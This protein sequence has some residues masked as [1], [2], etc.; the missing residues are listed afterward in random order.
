VTEETY[1]NRMDKFLRKALEEYKLASLYKLIRKGDVKVNGKRVKDP[2]STLEIGDEV[3]VWLPSDQ[4]KKDRIKRNTEGKREL[5]PVYMD[6]DIIMEDEDIMAINKDAG[7]S[8]HPGTGEE[9]R[10]TLIEGLM[11]YGQQNGFDPYLIHRLDRDTSGVLLVSKKRSLARRLSKLIADKN[12]Y[13]EYT[14][15]FSGRVSQDFICDNPVDDK[16]AVSRVYPLTLYVLENNV[17]MC[18]TLAKVVIESGRKHQ[19]RRHLADSGYPVVGDD[20]YGNREINHQLSSMGLKRQFLH[21]SKMSFFD[22]EQEKEY[23]LEAPLKEDL[24]GFLR[25]LKEV[26]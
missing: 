12:V 18:F 5:K 23:Y 3:S 11:H 19:I 7:V 13:K 25:R 26:D 16:W 24:K 10:A 6:L 20:K 22:L 2:S 17:Q 4:T 21:C 15:L 14:C 1:F 9:N 8:V